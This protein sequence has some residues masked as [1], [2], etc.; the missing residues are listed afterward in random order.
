MPAPT[1]QHRR[2]VDDGGLG[3]RAIH[4]DGRPGCGDNRGEPKGVAVVN[5]YQTTATV[6]DQGQVR[7]AGVPFAPGT[8]VEIAISPKRRPAEEFTAAR[9]RLCAELRNRPALKGITDEG[10]REEVERYRAGR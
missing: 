10:I 5:T 3:R 9:R 1:E 8:E 6:E 2:E 7:V 4:V